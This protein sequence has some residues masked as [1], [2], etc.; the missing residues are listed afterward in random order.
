MSKQKYLKYL[1]VLLWKFLLLK[2]RRL[3]YW[4]AT[5]L[6]QSSKSKNS[7]IIYELN[8]VSFF[9]PYRR[10]M[11]KLLDSRETAYVDEE[12]DAEWLKS[13][14]GTYDLELERMYVDKLKEQRN[15]VIFC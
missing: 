8:C 1:R 3:S 11:E 4:L 14:E 6:H 5:H 12:C 2:K 15:K 13:P 7:L 9:L 10:I